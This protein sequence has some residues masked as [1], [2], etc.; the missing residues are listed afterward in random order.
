MNVRG[1]SICEISYSLSEAAENCSCSATCNPCSL[2]E[3]LFS[4]SRRRHVVAIQGGHCSDY[5]HY[6]SHKKHD[7]IADLLVIMRPTIVG[8]NASR[9]EASVT[10]R[11]LSG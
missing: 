8:S 3:L 4:T 5:R 1:R 6:M 7:P 9:C 2:A 11:T 10:S